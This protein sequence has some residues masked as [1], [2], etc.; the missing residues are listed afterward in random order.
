[1]RRIRVRYGPTEWAP[2][3]GGSTRGETFSSFELE[4]GELIKA[5]Y[6][7]FDT[8][9]MLCKITFLTNGKTFG[10]YGSCS[11]DTE[12]SFIFPHGLFYISGRSAQYL[13]KLNFHSVC[14]YAKI[15][16]PTLGINYY[17]S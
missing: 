16:P 13:N 7:S 17:L 15:I 3:R 10:P 2:V 5:V 1:M 8:I 4:P 14:W 12:Q 9:D 6:V 11:R